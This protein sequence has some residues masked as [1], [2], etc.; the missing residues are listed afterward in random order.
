L[1]PPNSFSG[2]VLH[3]LGD[4]GIMTVVAAQHSLASS[5]AAIVLAA[6]AAGWSST[7]VAVETLPDAYVAENGTSVDARTYAG[8][9]AIRQFDC[10]RCHGAR[11]QGSS[12]P[13]LI[14]AARANSRAEFVRRLLE[15]NRD[16][17]MPPYRHVP[18]VADNAEGIYGYFKGRADGKITAGTLQLL[19]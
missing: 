8:W 19:R 12:G 7:P 2:R 16:R 13:S 3:S 15:G 6:V 1:W 4:A 9:R 5:C 10:A 14:E 11:Y 17:G 18:G